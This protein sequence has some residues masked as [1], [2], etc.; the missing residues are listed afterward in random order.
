VKTSTKV[1]IIFFSFVPFWAGSSALLY[2]HGVGLDWIGDV[3]TWWWCVF[4]WTV[5]QLLREERA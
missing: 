3:Q 5:F 4:I 1:L 2:L